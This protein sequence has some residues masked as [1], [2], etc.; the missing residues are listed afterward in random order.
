MRASPQATVRSSGFF[1]QRVQAA[2][3]DIA[4]KNPGHTGAHL[5]GVGVH[6]VA[7]HMSH[8]APVPV[9]TATRSDGPHLCALLKAQRCKVLSRARTEGLLVLGRVD[10]GQPHLDR[11]RGFVSG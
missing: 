11:L 2:V 9:E 8:G 10:L 6:A 5:L 4:V 1:L 7:A 3:D